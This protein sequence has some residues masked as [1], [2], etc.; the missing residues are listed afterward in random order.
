LPRLAFAAMA[1]DRR[2]ATAMVFAVSAVAIIGFVAMGTEVGNW[3]LQQMTAQNAADSAAISGALVAAQDI[4]ANKSSGT[5]TSDAMAA[6][7]S[8]ASLNGFATAGAM[9]VTPEY[10]PTFSSYASTAGATQADVSVSI[11]PILASLF[12]SSTPTVATR[13]IGLVTTNPTNPAC[14][15]STTYD[16]QITKAQ[17]SPNCTYASNS[18]TATAVDVV[19]SVTVSAYG[20]FSIGGCSAAGSTNCNA[21]SVQRLQ[22]YQPPAIN[23]FT[24]ID[25]LPTS[26]TLPSCTS[27]IV[28]SAVT[29]LT[30]GT[31]CP[32]S[33]PTTAT[34][35]TS[36]TAGTL[37][38]FTITSGAW[39]LAPGTYFFNGMSLSV[40]GGQI[41]CMSGSS[42][43]TAGTQGVT[44]VM[45]GSGS[46]SIGSL[47]IG[48]AATVMLGAPKTN[49]S[50]SALN[51]V[52]FYRDYRGSAGG[53]G[54]GAQV[55]NINGSITSHNVV[56]SGR[57]IGVS[58]EMMGGM[59]FPNAYVAYGGNSF[60]TCSILVGGA[61]LLNH[62]TS[63]TLSIATCPNY[64]YTTTYPPPS[65]SISYPQTQVARVVE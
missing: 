19:G 36:Y 58:P 45:T 3:Y 17:A 11:T 29:T 21:L 26:W 48:S 30:P 27:L 12:T 10:P 33:V 16:M 63:T 59:Y 8:G 55:V 56:I 34:T 20:V 50:F 15:L 54:S 6:A 37:P 43:C 40:T 49:S 35:W 25:A 38:T 52:L 22:P 18:T 32:S 9:T 31:Y 61:L 65:G 51:G 64:G 4:A 13:S 7:T 53:V 1:R 23:T 2:G 5:V 47:T 24:A 39:V 28:P 42:V 62:A 44:I 60:S 57:T 41:L 46:S 14:A